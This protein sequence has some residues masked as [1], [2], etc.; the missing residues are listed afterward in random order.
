MKRRAKRYDEGGVAEGQNQN[1]DDD[2]RARARKWLESGSPEQDDGGEDSKQRV[3]STTAKAS[4]PKME[5]R[6]ET[7]AREKRLRNEPG[8]E[9]VSP[10]SYLPIGSGLRIA[11][12]GARALAGSQ[13]RRAA[14]KEAEDL[15]IS[16]AMRGEAASQAKR[17]APDLISKLKDITGITA[18][19]KAREAEAAAAKT[20]ERAKK[21]EAGKQSARKGR[22]EASGA[23]PG[24]SAAGDF[25]WGFKKGGKASTKSYK[26]GGTVSKA[27]SRGD[28]IAQRGKTRGT[29]VACGG[30]YMK[31]KK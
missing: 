3:R 6:E 27:S 9:S 18:R 2:V 21:I 17:E 1:I 8:L 7:I 24:E 25:R 20:A 28:G 5:T 30:G 19:Q 31:G 29:I 16:G 15:A 14:A 23:M 11:Q 26:S 13:A 4:G 10:E 22:A 12:A